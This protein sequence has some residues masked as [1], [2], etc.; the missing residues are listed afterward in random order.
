MYCCCVVATRPARASFTDRA[1]DE[2]L[3]A[4]LEQRLPPGTRLVPEELARQLG[5]SVTPIKFALARLAA[6]GLV[7]ELSPYRTVVTRLEA[8]ALAALYDARLLLETASVREHAARV[9]SG[10]LAHLAAA[11]D[12]YRQIVTEVEASPAD[13]RLRRILVDADRAFHRVI[14]GLSE[15]PHVSR[16]YELA[17]THIQANRAVHAAGTLRRSV[18]EHDAILR[19]ASDGDAAGVEEAVRAHIAGARE[20]A[21]ALLAEAEHPALRRIRDTANT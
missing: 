4:I 16:W 7:E 10:F 18:E 1:Y 3:D 14:V 17:N 6:E 19:A 21:A 2:L 12:A 11:A 15:N 13:G 20:R 9:D 8:R 5:V